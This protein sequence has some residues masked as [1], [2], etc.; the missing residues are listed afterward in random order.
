VPQTP[1]L[2]ETVPLFLIPRGRLGGYL[3]AGLSL[4]ATVYMRTVTPLRSD[5][6]IEASL[7]ERW[8]I[9]FWFMYLPALVMVLLPAVEERLRRRT[10]MSMPRVARSEGGIA[11]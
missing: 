11:D 10:G 9:M 1:A 8:P 6:S 2:Y 5:M 3:L 7:A 4:A